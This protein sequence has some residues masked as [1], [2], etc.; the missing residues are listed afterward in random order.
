M[1]AVIPSLSPA[2]L[3]ELRARF[4][5]LRIVV[6]G[7]YCLDRYFDID[8]ALS[9]TSIETGLTVHNITGVRCQPGGA[10]TI[11]NNLSAL[12]I[13]EI[14][15][16]G[17]SG[18]DGEG[19]ELRNALSKV[20]GVKLEGF[21]T[22]PERHTFTYTKPL[23]RRDP[24]PPEELSRLDMKNW[25]PTPPNVRRAL[26]AAL[27]QSVEGADAL[28][29]L[30]QTDL[31]EIGA[32]DTAWLTH[33]GILAR[34][35]QK[36][37]VFADSRRGLSGWPPI[38]FKMNAAELAKLSGHAIEGRK[39]VGAAAATMAQR[40]G[41]PVFVTL[42]EHGIIAGSPD[43]SVHHIASLPV[44]GP[45]DIVGA[46]DSVTAN[47][48]TSLAAGGSLSEAMSQAMAAASVV[49]HQLGTTGTASVQQI[50]EVLR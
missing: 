33:D 34:L 38:I 43:G 18:E 47:L 49:I 40:N 45:I 12:G 37:P 24:A 4:A 3:R 1:S 17:F 19:W 23:L 30:E 48:T 27:E 5:E 39:Q 14:R 44:R 2:R 46:G 15:V 36:I 31:P 25:T 35:A 22:S 7:D 26:R 8:P 20:R 13:K 6:A 11:V 21:V 32:I 10:G 42:S 16:V 41:Q 50:G 9:E 29:V 28:I